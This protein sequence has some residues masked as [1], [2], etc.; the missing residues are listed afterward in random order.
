VTIGLT[1]TDALLNLQA[2]G[3]E[4]AASGVT[5]VT[6]PDGSRTYLVDLA[7]IAAG[8]AVNLS[9]DLI[10]FG[11]TAPNLGS[12][13]TVSNVRL[14]GMAQTRDDSATT[15]EDTVARIIALAND[16]DANQAG[17][18]PVIVAAPQHGLVVVNIDGT[19]SYTPA[20]D[21]FGQDSFTYRLSNG[22]VD[23]NVST[24]SSDHYPGE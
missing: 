22:V 11:S 14:M 17:M 1:H 24:V 16:I 8:T 23:S 6:N 3:A 21:Y 19:F 4:L 2:S 9:F 20:Q 13:A 18:A 7:G 10:G 15:F 5:H 12:H